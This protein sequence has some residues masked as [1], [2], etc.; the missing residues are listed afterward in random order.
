M[1]PKMRDAIKLM[2]NGEVFSSSALNDL[3][4]DRRVVKR[5]IDSRILMQVR[6][7]FYE[8]S[9]EHK[10]PVVLTENDFQDIEFLRDAMVLCAPSPAAVCLYTAA[11]WHKMTNHNLSSEVM[12][13]V[14]YAR[15]SV[16]A[17]DNF[18]FIRMR[19]DAALTEGIE[20]IPFQG[21]LLNIT[22]PPRT[23]VDLF[24]YSPLAGKTEKSGILIDEEAALTAFSNYRASDAYDA[25]ELYRI[26][27]V[28][29]VEEPIA[30]LMKKSEVIADEVIETDTSYSPR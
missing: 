19:Q 17:N 21:V 2:E 25:N 14:P 15:G 18:R 27:E 29:G 23:V 7:G 12:C 5:M 9:E 13:M 11:D 20:Q 1:G 16:P 3:G 30:L 24:R 28:F 6:R 8:L 26:A 4:I 10:K 22:N